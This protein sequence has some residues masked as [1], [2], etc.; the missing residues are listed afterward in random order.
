MLLLI[1]S[2]NLFFAVPI[3][4]RLNSKHY[5]VMKIL[6]KQ[7][8]QQIASTIDTTLTSGNSSRFKKII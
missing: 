2:Y 8:L 4:I 5:F 1:L 3:N 7:Q 6:N